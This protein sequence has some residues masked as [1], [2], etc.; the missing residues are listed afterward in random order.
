MSAMPT[1]TH[2]LGNSKE[3]GA[4]ANLNKRKAKTHATE[5]FFY[6]MGR[7]IGRISPVLPKSCIPGRYVLAAV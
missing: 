4:A 2:T 3:G 1:L 5:T 7:T 6:R